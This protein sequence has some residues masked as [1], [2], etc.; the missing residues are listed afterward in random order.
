MAKDTFELSS[1][2]IKGVQARE[3]QARANDMKLYHEEM[4]EMSISHFYSRYIGDTVTVAFNG[5]FRKFPVTG[6]PFRISKGH[7][8]ALNK[9]LRH[10]DRQVKIQ[11]TNAK[12]MNMDVSGD[13]KKL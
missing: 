3:T 5:N 4:I 7:A 6:E 11:K 9:Y 12:F 8:N 10:V 2:L 1:Q 13:F